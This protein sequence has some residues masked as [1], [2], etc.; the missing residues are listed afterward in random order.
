MTESESEMTLNPIRSHPARPAPATGAVMEIV[1][2]RLIDGIDAEAHLADARA[3]EAYLRGTGAVRRRA[4]TVDEDG[5]WTDMIEW[6]S[7]D[8]ARAAEEAAMSRPEF[9]A[10]FGAMDGKTVDMRHCPILWRMD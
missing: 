4:L 7:L 2:Y 1:T 10:F 6:T 3:T 8:A 5:V 9:A